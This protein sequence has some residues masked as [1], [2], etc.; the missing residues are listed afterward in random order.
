MCYGLY[1]KNNFFDCFVKVLLS[2]SLFEQKPCKQTKRDRYKD[3]EKEQE[4]VGGK[5]SCDTLQT[6]RCACTSV[7]R[8]SS[9]YSVVFNILMT[10]SL[11]MRY[12]LNFSISHCER[13][14][15]ISV[16]GF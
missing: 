1:L 7:H 15:S 14:I 2:A 12:T 5:T 8:V 10:R 9:V 13:N 3:R 4:R 11:L 16:R 6:N